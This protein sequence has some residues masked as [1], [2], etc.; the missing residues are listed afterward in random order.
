MGEGDGAKAR[1]KNMHT[2]GRIWLLLPK[3]DDTEKPAKLL[4]QKL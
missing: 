2:Y 4:A 1:I 3:R